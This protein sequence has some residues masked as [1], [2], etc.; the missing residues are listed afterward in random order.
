M[1]KRDGKKTSVMKRKYKY[2]A[3]IVAT[4]CYSSTWHREVT[5]G[6]GP[7]QEDEGPFC[8]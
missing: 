8:C 5:A 1:V 7:L 3:T 4:H 6:E 2:L